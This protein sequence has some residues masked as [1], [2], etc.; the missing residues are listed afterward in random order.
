MKNIL[1]LC[2][3]L[4]LSGFVHAQD[5]KSEMELLTQLLGMNKKAMVAEFVDL[6]DNDVFWIL[7]KEYEEQRKEIGEERYQLLI[8]YAENF[9][10]HSDKKLEELMEA[11][12]NLRNKAET[13]L[14][15]F[16]L[17]IKKEC[18]IK[19]AS[20]FYF[21]QRFCES[22]LSANVLGSLPIVEK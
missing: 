15:T 19:T 17:K 14:E 10:N 5:E 2:I 3:L 20:Q 6:P 9:V 18:G 4:L 16:Y 8:Q 22:T 21:V 1:S 13:N 7:Y 12:M 11:S